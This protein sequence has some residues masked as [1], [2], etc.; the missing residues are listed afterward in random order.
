MSTIKSNIT[1]SNARL[2]DLPFIVSVYNQTIASRMVTADTSPVSIESRLDWFNAHNA[3]KRPLWLIKYQNEPCGWVSLS[4][5]Y[6]RPAYGK[7]VEI[8]LYIDQAYRGKKIGQYT[9]NILERH[10]INNGIETI[11]CYIFAHNQPS[12]SLFTKLNY[13][14]WGYLH[15]VAELDNVKR[16]LIILG[17]KLVK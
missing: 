5:F 10:A 16:D 14:Q 13:Q 2:A 3:D 15:E 8:S 6:G 9:V 11:L 12:L 17:K 4:S 7:T 1:V